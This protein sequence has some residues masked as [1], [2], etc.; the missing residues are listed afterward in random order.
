MRLPL[1]LKSRVHWV[2]ELGLCLRNPAGNIHNFH[3]RR[4]RADK[5]IHTIFKDNAALRGNPKPLGSKEKWLWMR[6]AVGY[7]FRADNDIEEI[8]DARDA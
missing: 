7:I 4:V 3:P 8:D 5:A 6:L 1:L 2:T